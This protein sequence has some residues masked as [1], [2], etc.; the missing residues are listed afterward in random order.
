MGLCY[1]GV[2]MATDYDCW[3]ETEAKVE[4]AN[5]LKIF[6]ENVEKVTKIICGTIKLIAEKEW[7]NTI[8]KLQVSNLLF[9]KRT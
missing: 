3:H 1:A 5:V 4:V 2:A 9:Y 8:N 7:E 6:K